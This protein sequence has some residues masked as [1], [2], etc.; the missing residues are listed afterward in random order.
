MR[1]PIV[2][3][4]MLAPLLVAAAGDATRFHPPAAAMDLQT[5][6]TATLLQPL[7]F[8]SALAFSY[9]H[10]P[11]VWR[12]PDGSY[13][14]IIT[15]QGMLELCL[16]FG[17]VKL[18]DFGV[19]LPVALVNRGPTN[20]GL[21]LDPSGATLNGRGFGDLRLI[22]RI[23]FVQERS[24]G[25]GLAVAAELSAPTG[26]ATRFLGEPGW[27]FRPRVIGTLPVRR[28]AGVPL[29]FSSS[30]GYVVRKSNDVAGLTVG[31]ELELRAG[32]EATFHRLPVPTSLLLDFVG[33]TAA[34]KPFAGHGLA[35][36][37]VL[38]GVRIRLNDY[39]VVTL[40]GGPGLS[41]GLGTPDVRGVVSIGLAPEPPDRDGDGIS[42]FNDACPD[43]PEDYDQFDDLDGCP[44]LD[45]DDDGVPD[46]ADRCPNEAEDF[47][48]VLDEDGCPDGGI[49]DRDGDGLPDDQD[50]CPDQPEDKDG[51]EDED[52]CPDP[53]NDHDG[54]PDALDKCPNEKETINGI[55]DDDGCPDEGEGQTEVIEN[56]KIEIKA[57]VLFET[58]KATIKE[59]SKTLLDQVAL[60][61]LAHAEIK[62]LRIEGHTDSVGPA[63]DNLYLS[64][65]RADA[66]RRYLISRK[67]AAERLEAVGYG[68][69]RPIDSNDTAEGRSRNRRVEF[70]ILNT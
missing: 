29:R 50:L 22:P 8:S 45:N 58:S 52:G 68:E 27:T 24:F 18:V 55:D 66:V 61:M 21:G 1:C 46:T 9:A 44:D 48:G 49:S 62:R 33:T 4:L 6:E 54:V 19:V 14:P 43:E 63:D 69:T 32:A 42:D 53:D 59:Q 10:N 51:F 31:D 39:L 17:L 23:A 13:D 25:F 30:L 11:V 12:Y 67:V 57:T 60:Q 37:E 26:A 7:Q 20:N 35:N 56:V 34:R 3:L 41:N 38:A 36:V 15:D 5:T 65:D 47:E 28:F 70:V 2:A 16:A 40:G 64:Q